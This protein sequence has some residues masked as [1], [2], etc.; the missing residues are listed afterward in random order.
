MKKAIREGAP[1]GCRNGWIGSSQYSSSHSIGGSTSKLRAK[2]A[3][4]LIIETRVKLKAGGR[5][6]RQ[7]EAKRLTHHTESRTSVPCASSRSGPGTPVPRRPASI[8]R[9]R[10]SAPQRAQC[11]GARRRPTVRGKG[12]NYCRTVDDLQDGVHAPEPAVAQ[13]RQASSSRACVRQIPAG[14]GRPAENILMSCGGI[15]AQQSTHTMILQ[16]T[17]CSPS[18]KMVSGQGGRDLLAGIG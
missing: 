14:N 9:A 5:N 7:N 11:G 15:L 6:R 1:G 10:Q 18:Q 16:I 8:A 2:A 3:S 13:Y 17:Q 4:E 12:N